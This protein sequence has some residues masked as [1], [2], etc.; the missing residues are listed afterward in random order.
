M[1]QKLLKM[2]GMYRKIGQSNFYNLKMAHTC[3]GA[4]P[5]MSAAL[6]CDNVFQTTDNSELSKAG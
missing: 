1:K 4:S 3:E 6:N 2:A 5:S